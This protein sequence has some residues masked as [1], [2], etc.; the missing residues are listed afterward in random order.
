[1]EKSRKEKNEE[2]ALF[3][4]S[5]IDQWSESGISQLAYC[6]RHELIPH[7]FGY[8]RRKFKL[9]DLPV[10]LVQIPETVQIQQSDLKLN[11]NSGL[12]L[13]IPDGFSKTTL[14]E[15]L[16]TLKVLR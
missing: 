7:R 14:K 10:K 5:H 4:K 13:E 2:L 3:W 12:Q 6:R 1:M 15:V 9:Q 8:W 11:I 16:T